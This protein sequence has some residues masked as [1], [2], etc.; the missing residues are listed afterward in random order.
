MISNVTFCLFLDE[1]VMSIRLFK[2]AISL[3]LLLLTSNGLAADSIRKPPNDWRNYKVIT[4]DN[5]ME[6]ILISDLGT[7]KVGASLSVQVGYYQDPKSQPGLAHYTEHMLFLGTKKYPEPG[8]YQKFIQENGGVYNAV[9]EA[10]KTTYFFSVSQQ[11]FPQAL[12]RFSDFFKTPLLD[13]TYS[14]KELSTINSEWSS[15][16]ENDNQIRLSLLGQVINPEHPLAR[17]NVGNKESL[18][19]KPGSILHEELLAF[20]NQYYMANRMKLVL[21]GNKS[22]QELQT[23]ADEYF[24]LIPSNAAKKIPQSITGFTKEQY[25]QHVH[26]ATHSN[27]NALLLRFPIK[28]NLSDWRVKPNQ[29]LT[30]MFT[31]SEKGTLAS[32]LKERHLVS[33]LYV[34]ILPNLFGEDGL[35]EVGL[36]LTQKGKGKKDE[37]IAAILAYIELLNTQGIQKAY[38]Q[39]LAELAQ[40]HFS[41]VKNGSL[42]E[43]AP[44]ISQRLFYVPAKNLLDT[45][46]VYEKFNPSVIKNLLEQLQVSKVMIWHEGPNEPVDT[47]IPYYDGRYKTSKITSL[48]FK[49]WQQLSGNWKFSLP[50]IGAETE[51]ANVQVVNA[52][53]NNPT[54]I[55]NNNGI[56]AWLMHSQ[57][58]QDTQGLFRLILDS[59]IGDKDASSFAISTILKEMF[60]QEHQAFF[61]RISRSNTGILIDRTEYNSLYFD[62]SGNTQ[63]HPRLSKFRQPELTNYSHQLEHHHPVSA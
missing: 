25:G 30:Y 61:N 10:T 49:R 24:S 46:A 50:P 51:E 17:L 8:G 62:L 35:F 18:S 23:L 1:V 54:L 16:R 3:C 2:Y 33:G 53:L 39:E 31:S 60:V 58:H 7:L 48:E 37:I 57:Y 12:E 27:E 4:L 56:Q 40:E 43:S 55:V 26:Y 38:Y 52:V 19:D 22:L 9:T 36:R 41:V 21:W 34:D 5:G 42:A 59:N 45:A 6:V 63:K 29:Y 13:K 20:F 32:Q 47:D 44:H 11:V 14:Q 15:I 28:N